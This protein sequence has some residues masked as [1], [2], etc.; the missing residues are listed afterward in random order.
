MKPQQ[1][2]GPPAAPYH[3]RFSDCEMCEG[4]GWRCGERYVVPCPRCI[5]RHA[6]NEFFN[7]EMTTK[8]VLQ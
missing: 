3:I 2:S 4:T 6:T 5:R 1:L 8:G 7:S